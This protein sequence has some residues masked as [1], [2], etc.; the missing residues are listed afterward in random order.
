MA[1]PSDLELQGMNTLDSVADWTGLA[2]GADSPRAALYTLFGAAGANHPRILGQV[3]EADFNTTLGSW[4]V[5][6]SGALVPP[7]ATQLGAARLF[8]KVCRIIGG[9]QESI[10]A[11]AAAIAKANAHALALAKATP[12]TAAAAKTEMI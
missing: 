7:N 11:K 1:E 12:P 9:T 10:A 6:P 8:H 4:Q 5:G 2:G 3:S